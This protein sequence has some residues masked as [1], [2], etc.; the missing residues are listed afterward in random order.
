MK[1][2]RGKRSGRINDVMIAFDAV[3]LGVHA[4]HPTIC[5]R[6]FREGK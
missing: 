1:K 4:F 3:S 2:Q 5:E 6:S